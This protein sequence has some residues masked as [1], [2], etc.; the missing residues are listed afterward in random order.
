MQVAPRPDGS[1]DHTRDRPTGGEGAL[2][3]RG[4]AVRCCALLYAAVRSCARPRSV[5]DHRRYAGIGVGL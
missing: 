5:W 2:G 3:C 1:L 4:V